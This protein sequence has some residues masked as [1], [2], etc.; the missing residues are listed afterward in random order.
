MVYIMPLFVSLWYILNKLSDFHEFSLGI[1]CQQLLSH[2]EYASIKRAQ[3]VPNVWN[4]IMQ[5]I[6]SDD[7]LI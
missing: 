3:V 4:R 7:G 1:L 5:T 2:R 6:V